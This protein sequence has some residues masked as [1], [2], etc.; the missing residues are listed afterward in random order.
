MDVII[1]KSRSRIERG[2]NDRDEMAGSNDPAFLAGYFFIL[3]NILRLKVQA[4]K[5][6]QTDPD[7][8]LKVK[9]LKSPQITQVK[10]TASPDVSFYFRFWKI[11]SVLSAGPLMV[12]NFFYFAVPEMFKI[13]LYTAS[14]KRFTNYLFIGFL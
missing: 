11:I 2:E 4:I 8:I 10:G 12:F 13:D 7:T 3:I 5:S 6:S 9:F 14:M 1:D